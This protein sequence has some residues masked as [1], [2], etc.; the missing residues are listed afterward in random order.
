MNCNCTETVNEKIREA[1]GDPDAHLDY[2]WTLDKGLNNRMFVTYT[3]RD[4][5][6]DGT[7]TKDKQG[8]LALS[9]CPFCGKPQQ[10]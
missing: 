5:K 3:F 9:K 8:K 2:L 7:F 10:P 6:R 4:K 1:T